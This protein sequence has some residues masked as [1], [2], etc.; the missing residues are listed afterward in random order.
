MRE[1][2]EKVKRELFAKKGIAP[3]SIEVLEDCIRFPYGEG[4]YL[5]G[6]KAIA[7]YYQK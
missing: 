5:V 3:H 6:F 7:R 2:I 4:T 1:L